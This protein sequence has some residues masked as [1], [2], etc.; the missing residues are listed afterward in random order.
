[1][2]E[3]GGCK[4]S[5]EIVETLDPKSM[6]EIYDNHDCSIATSQLLLTSNRPR[7]NKAVLAL[8]K[9]KERALKLRRWLV[10]SE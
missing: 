5:Y 6:K 4:V 7:M 8:Q 3:G 9:V 2:E 1:M 10:G